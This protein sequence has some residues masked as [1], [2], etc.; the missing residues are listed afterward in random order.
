[1]E[2]L[3]TVQKL[4]YG[5]IM[6]HG[7]ALNAANC[8]ETEQATRSIELNAQGLALPYMRLNG[9]TTNQENCISVPPWE[10]VRPVNIC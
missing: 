10:F 4:Y 3:S 9:L 6:L 8:L 2:I 1:M 5:A 7:F